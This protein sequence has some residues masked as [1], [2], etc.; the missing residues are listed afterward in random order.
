MMGRY[1]IMAVVGV[2]AMAMVGSGAHAAP[3]GTLF[4]FG[5]SL[6]DLKN[7][8][9]LIY[10]A[11]S[12]GACGNGKGLLQTLPTYAP[13]S[14]DLAN[15]YAAGGAGTGSFNVAS[16]VTPKAIG[17]LTQVNAFTAAGGRIGGRDLVLVTGR[18]NF[19]QFLF[20]PTL[21]GA[22]LATRALGEVDQEIAGLV[23]AGAR[24]IVYFDT[25]SPTAPDSPEVNTY[26][27]NFSTGLRS[28]LAAYARPGVRLRL[29]NYNGL[30]AAV[31]ADPTRYGFATGLSCAADPGCQASSI[32]V[33]DQHFLFDQHPTEAGYDL[34]A[35]FIAN[36]DASADGIA[37]QANVAA[38]ASDAFATTLLDRASVDG[39]LAGKRGL[40]VDGSYAHDRRH[41][42]YDASGG[43]AGYSD[44][45]ARVVVGYSMPIGANAVAG[46]AGGYAHSNASLYDNAGKVRADS[47][48]GGAYLDW[49]QGPAFF[50]AAASYT[51]HDLDVR[52]SGV[53]D[54]LRAKPD[55]WTISAQ[56][57]AGWLVDVGSLRAGPIVKLAYS[58]THVDGYTESGDPLLTQAV[59]DTTAKSAVGGVG[60][61]LETGSASTAIAGF[62]ELSANRD[63]DNGR[64]VLRT[65]NT[66]ALDLPIYTVVGS[67]WAGR[68]FGQIDGALT[69]AL[70]PKVQLNIRGSSTV[71]R[72]DASSYAVEAGIRVT[73]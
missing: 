51:H 40:F 63:F 46:L 73:L 68:T 47:Y 13:Y 44:E 53:V 60:A 39:A 28:T 9:P 3:G 37:A 52:R 14:F 22:P 16:V 72:Q 11:N 59:D 62:L 38:A 12:F 34:I 30:S 64:R 70:T 58:R 69:G 55:A 25:R 71:F 19:F 6:L 8:C 65:A 56:A 45:I 33:Q 57:R 18:N 5:D 31:A 61:R 24:D 49:R 7:V 48:Q 27:A 29:L 17:T 1:G 21:A 15:D 36:L 32:T 50:D 26:E 35:R 43:S 2:G 42:R 41:S 23:G 66:Y 20:D 54:E 67:G 10:P 4:G